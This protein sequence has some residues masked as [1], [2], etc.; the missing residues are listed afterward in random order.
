ML[1]LTGAGTLAEQRQAAGRLVEAL[2]GAGFECVRVKIEASPWAD[3]VPKDDVQAEYLDPEQYF[4]HHIKLLLPE[5]SDLEAL[6]DL[7]AP[8]EA[9]LSWNA[10]RIVSDGRQER[11]VTQRCH[12]TGLV[13]A[14]AR[15]KALTSALRSAGHHLLSVEREFVVH[16]SNTA[17]DDGWIAKEDAQ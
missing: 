17:I 14:G 16:D 8:H 4:E 10:R 12:R 6:T 9:H 13:N 11:F 15:L 1:T 2:E 7:V 5:D 3:G